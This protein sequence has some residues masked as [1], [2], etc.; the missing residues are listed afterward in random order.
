MWSESVS[1]VDVNSP[2]YAYAAAVISDSA[3]RTKPSAARNSR[4]VYP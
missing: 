2:T 3:T 4:F 1:V